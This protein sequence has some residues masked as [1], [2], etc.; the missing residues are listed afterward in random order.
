MTRLK[1]SLPVAILT[2]LGALG[3]AGCKDEA[4]LSPEEQAAFNGPAHGSSRS[5]EAKAAI[6][7]FA[8]NYRKTHPS[9]GGSPGSGGPPPQ[10]VPGG[11]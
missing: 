2:L 1:P 5:P 10:A 8:E 7:N 11:R 6:S 3:L 4:S 9:A